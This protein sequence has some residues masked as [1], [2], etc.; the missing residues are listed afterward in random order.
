M[1][2]IELA[3][4]KFCFRQFKDFNSNTTFS[5][6][7]QNLFQSTVL[8][9]KKTLW[10]VLQEALRKGSSFLF[11]DHETNSPLFSGANSRYF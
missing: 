6:Q 3:P 11:S 2:L 10:F 4:S 8:S 7:N 1:L 5:I 9:L